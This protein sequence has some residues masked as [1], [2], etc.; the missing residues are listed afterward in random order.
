V[1]NKTNIKIL[2]EKGLSEI[3]ETKEVDPETG[4]KKQRSDYNSVKSQILISVNPVSRLRNIYGFEIN[5]L[6]EQKRY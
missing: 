1:L 2:V 4:E 3:I 6:K 5:S